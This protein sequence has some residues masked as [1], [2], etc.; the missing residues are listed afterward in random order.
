VALVCE[1]FDKAIAAALGGS[2]SGHT[3]KHLLAAIAL[4]VI[5]GML[6]ARR[7]SRAS[8]AG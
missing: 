1:R 6:R 3:L 5:V 8:P 4:L 2:V 7:R